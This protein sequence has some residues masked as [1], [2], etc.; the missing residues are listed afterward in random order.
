MPAGVRPTAGAP[1]H[2]TEPSLRG[3]LRRVGASVGVAVAAGVLAGL[4]DPAPVTGATTAPAVPTTLG[5]SGPPVTAAPR[6]TVPP[7]WRMARPV[8]QPAVIGG[9][10]VRPCPTMAAAVR[11]WPVRRQVAQ[12]LGV[13]IR[14]GDLAVAGRRAAAEGIGTILVTGVGPDG[15]D[16]R[17]LLDDVRSAGGAVPPMFAVDQE[18]GSV[19]VLRPVLGRSASARR[20][21]RSGAASFAADRAAQAEAVRALGFD[22]LLAPVL[23]VTASARGVIADRAISGDPSV[24]ASLGAVWA[25]AVRAAGMVPVVK[26]WP[27][28]GGTDIDTHRRRGLL[29]PLDVL[30]RT[31]LPPFDA[32]MAAGPVAVM[33]GHLEVPGLTGDLPASVSA[34]AMIGELRVK[35]GFRGLVMTDSLSMGSINLRWPEP[36]AAVR[37]VSAG[38]DVA[39]FATLPDWTAV[40]DALERAVV[41]GRIPPVAGGRLRDAGPADQGALPGLSRPRQTVWARGDPRSPRPRRRG[42]CGPTVGAPCRRSRHVTDSPGGRVGRGR[43]PLS[44]DVSVPHTDAAGPP[45]PRPSCPTRS[46]RREE[47]TMTTAFRRR[48]S[49]LLIA[50][51]CC[52]AGAPS[53]LPAAQAATD[54]FTAVQGPRQFS[55]THVGSV[56][57]GALLGISVATD[58]TAVAYLCDGTGKVSIWFTGRRERAT[59]VVSLG[60]TTGASLTYDLKAARAQLTMQGT[61]STIR[62]QPAVSPAGIYRTTTTSGGSTVVKGWVVGNDGS[63]AGQVTIDGKLLEAASTN[64]AADVP[65]GSPT[66]SAEV[67]S[68]RCDV[69]QF[70]LGW[71]QWSGERLALDRV[72]DRGVR[73]G[74]IEAGTPTS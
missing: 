50:A 21:A 5:P 23:D 15:D 30:A 2:R 27:G 16:L 62:L 58:G 67:R 70:R 69:L 57:G 4:L 28:H 55:V 68:F 54:P 20:A 18:G 37:A 10:A 35:R 72:L 52:M 1:L 59:G 25:E 49:A 3:R 17:R 12:L 11:R 36:L 24:V 45:H 33:I 63:L 42:A 38:A 61:R 14:Q 43:A 53:A 29:P 6:G 7:D 44:G 9:G 39:L 60:A 73:L 65:Q 26:H 48:R 74:C 71:L 40:L 13:G 19:Q 34:N 64:L 47:P 46:E 66:P 41:E 32:V 8:A 56:P 51:A 22:V 31:D